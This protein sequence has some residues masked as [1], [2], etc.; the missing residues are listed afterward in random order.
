MYDIFSLKDIHM[1]EGFLW[2]S[3]YAGHQVEGMNVNSQRWK[4]EQEGRTA[5]K[6]GMACNSYALYKEDV[7]LVQKLGHQAFRTSV[8]WSRIEPEEGKFCEEAAQHYVDFFR[9]LSEAGI[10]VFATMVH[11]SHPQWFE[12]RGH[13]KNLENIKY[14]QR[15]LTYI[16]PRIAPYVSFWNVINVFNLSDTEERVGSLYFHAAGYHTIHQFSDAPVSSAHALLHYMPQRAYDRYDNLMTAMK[17]WEYNEFFFHAV[18]TGEIIL[19]HRDME[20]VPE[21]KGTCD[22]WS[23]NIYVR[24]MVDSRLKNLA[25]KRY[26]HKVL[27]MSPCNFYLEEMYPEGMISA[28]LRL[29]DKPVYIT[30]NGCSTDDDRFRIVYLALHFSAIREAIDMGADVRGYLQW[31]LLD[32]YEW[33]SFKPKFGM[34][35]VD[36]ETFERKIKPSACFYKDIIKENGCTQKI[37][38]EY[39][40]RNPS[41]VF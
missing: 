40:D 10:K 36:R 9:M 33:S 6:S 20:I 27:K 34:V 28:L 24:E 19:P 12:E 8:E 15:Y 37:I 3:G 38:R 13:F 16:V 17:D 14:F 29:T 22:F 18:R 35:A 32:N 26:D 30:E 25:G 31:S 23:I 7:S 1:P 39:L 11:V 21:L 41:L 5:E 2:G 4:L